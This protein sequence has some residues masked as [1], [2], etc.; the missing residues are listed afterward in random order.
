MNEDLLAVC[1][2]P[3]R[4][5]RPTLAAHL[6]PLRIAID[7]RNGIED[8][9]S[10]AKDNLFVWRGL[11]LL[12]EEKLEAFFAIAVGKSTFTEAVI[13][14]FDI[15]LPPPPPPPSPPMEEAGGEEVPEGE[16]AKGGGDSA[17]SAESSSATM[18]A[19]G[20]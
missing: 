12:A 18:A 1:A 11:R 19:E 5:V 20:K 17:P 16:A 15:V 7:P 10:P 13:E 9:Y 14:A 2:D 6:V 8:E 3:A 4:A